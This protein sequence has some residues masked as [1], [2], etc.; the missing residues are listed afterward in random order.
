MLLDN[1]GVRRTNKDFW[2]FSDS[3]HDTYMSWHPVD[4]GYLDFNRLENR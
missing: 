1:F 4:A 2:R 3:I